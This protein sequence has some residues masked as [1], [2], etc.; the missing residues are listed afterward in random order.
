MSPSS[1]TSVSRGREWNRLLA[2]VERGTLLLTGP[3]GSGKSTLA[4][5]L[6]GQLA[7]DLERVALVDCDPGQSSVGVPGCLGLALT[8]PWEAPAASWFVGA[9]TPARHLLPIV[10]GAARLAEHAR[11]RG[12]QAVVLDAPGLAE[13]PLARVLHYHL[14]ASTGVDQVIA[15]AAAESSDES[16]ELLALLTTPDRRV[17]R[18]AP[19][20]GA[21]ERS[22]EERRSHRE[23]RFAAHLAGA[24]TRLF[25]P[26]RVIGPDWRLGGGGPVALGTVLGLLGGDGFCL[27]LGVVE[28]V[29][30]DRLA[31]STRVT[32]VPVV[33]LIAADFRLDGD[34][35]E[36]PA[37]AA[38]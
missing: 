23:A 35:R 20:A 2:G 11:A 4:R 28:E 26:R 34:R 18:V 17:S 33:R 9:A 36:L 25:S 14:A 3:S 13:G 5:W 1:P 16:G 32:D 12:A 19:A 6:V 22:Q 10:V 27:G 29:H 21:R 24:S 38:G 8:G 30:E 7:R 31:V 37:A 15:I